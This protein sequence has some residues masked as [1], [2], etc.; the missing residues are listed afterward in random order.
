MTKRCR[1]CP[2]ERRFPDSVYLCDDH[3]RA[4]ELV[5]EEADRPTPNPA[6]GTDSDFAPA[7]D[8]VAESPAAGSG[9]WN[10]GRPPAHPDNRE[11]QH[12]HRRLLPPDMVIRFQNGVVPVDRGARSELGRVGEHARLFRGYPN[13][14]RRHAVIGV[15]PDGRAWIEPVPTPNGT[16]VD[17][18][19]ILASVRHPLRSAQTVRLARN[20][21][22]SVQLYSR[23][24]GGR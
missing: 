4:L 19:E 3:V 13:V 12:C 10:C 15:E 11:C 21:E 6:P 22:G 17:G 7:A 9:C 16:F 18:V 1:E 5:V 20:V 24:G 23:P 2:P 8:P 14:S